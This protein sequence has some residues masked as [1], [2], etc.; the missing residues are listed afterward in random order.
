MPTDVSV[1]QLPSL[2][3]TRSLR[4]DVVFLPLHVVVSLLVALLGWTAIGVGVYE[5]L[6]SHY[7]IAIVTGLAGLGLIAYA[8]YT[9]QFGWLSAPVVY[10]ILFWVFHFG[11]TFTAAL[12]PSLL[13]S[14]TDDG[15]EWFSW[16][17]VRMTMILSLTGQAAFVCGVGL[18]GTS[19]SSREPISQEP[20]RSLHAGGWLFMLGGIAASYTIV[21]ATVGLS[22]FSIGYLPFLELAS[23]T[24]LGTALWL[25]NFGCLL[26]ICGAKGRARFTPFLVWV[27]LIALPTLILGSRSSGLV[28][29]VGFAVILTHL[30]VKFSRGM[31]TAVLLCVLVAIPASEAFRTVGFANRS[32]VNWTDVTPLDTLVELGGS[33]QAARAYVDWIEDG[34]PYLLGAS[35]WA[36]FDRQ[37]LVRIIPGRELIPFEQD[38]RLPGRLMVRE[39]PIGLSATGEAY[40]NFGSVG[41]F[42]YFGFV[43]LLFGWLDRRATRSPYDCAALGA[44]MFLFFF[45]LRSEWYAIPA[46]LAESFALMACCWVF[47]RPAS[48]R[49]ES[50]VAVREA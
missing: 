34:E 15:L 36:P 26:A 48:T 24:V 49:A 37:V 38:E 28:P 50:M 44:V 32:E 8:R 13:D 43:G 2:A 14:I 19:A 5:P 25:S 23:T 1:G 10:L 42:I 35:Y 29:L 40:F 27:A 47:D 4:Q 20:S 18:F 30:G 7:S 6:S 9:L 22:V 21:L 17:S 46:A 45:N 3:G 16:P 11:M 39:G 12:V 33:L 31:L 41:P